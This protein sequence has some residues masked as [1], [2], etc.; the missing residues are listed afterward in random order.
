MPRHS[1]LLDGGVSVCAKGDRNGIK[2]ESLL[3]SLSEIPRLQSRPPITFGIS[4]DLCILLLEF[5]C[6][7]CNQCS[8]PSRHQPNAGSLLVSRRQSSDFSI[9][10]SASMWYILLKCTHRAAVHRARPNY[11]EH[12]ELPSGML[13]TIA[14]QHRASTKLQSL[15]QI[16]W[17]GQPLVRLIQI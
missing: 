11:I 9:V 2:N 10:V 1:S 13:V 12:D 8:L 6:R 14:H 16:S 15:K 7:I 3:L 17:P 4:G 5:R